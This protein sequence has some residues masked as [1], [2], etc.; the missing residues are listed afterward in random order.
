VPFDL[1][2]DDDHHT[3]LRIDIHGDST[4][5]QQY[6][7]VDEAVETLQ[8]VSYRLD[9][10]VHIVGPIPPGDPIPHLKDAV[11]KLRAC[12]N[13]G[14]VVIVN[15]RTFYRSIAELVLRL[16]YRAG[17]PHHGGFVDTLDDARQVIAKNR[18]NAA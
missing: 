16:A 7:V 5:E 9:V 2:W 14:L 3:I 4:W 6:K 11:S 17:S 13:L 8:G 1:H 18:A 12:P 10:I 15:K